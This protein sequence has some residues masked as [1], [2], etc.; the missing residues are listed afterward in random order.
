MCKET[1][2]EHGQNRSCVAPYDCTTPPATLRRP[3]RSPSTARNRRFRDT[4][5][6]YAP[7]TAVPTSS[8]DPNPVTSYRNAG[9]PLSPLVPYIL[10]ARRHTSSSSTDFGSNVSD[11]AQVLSTNPEV[12]P[13]P[14]PIL[15]TV[16]FS[17]R[18]PALRVMIMGLAGS[19]VTLSGP[20]SPSRPRIGTWRCVGRAIV[21]F[22]PLTQDSH[23]T[24]TS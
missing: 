10:T 12:H 22:H 13:E 17:A 7:P 23:S 24:S 16:S 20:G 6:S 2:H 1:N 11:C 5:P 14:I 3:L 8:A 19:I 18:T 9:P 15:S 4:L 21:P